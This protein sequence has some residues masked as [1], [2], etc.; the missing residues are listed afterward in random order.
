MGM[1]VNFP[2]CV[3]QMQA[4]GRP[5]PG[6]NPVQ[7][8]K[9]RILS[10]DEASGSAKNF[11]KPASDE[12]LDQTPSENRPKPR[13]LQTE[14][15]EEEDVKLFRMYKEYGSRWAVIVKNFKGKTKDGLR[16]RFYSTLR[17]IYRK[18]LKENPSS[19]CKKNLLDYV[20]D[21]I[22]Y[23]HNCFCKR[24]RPKKNTKENDKMQEVLEEKKEEEPIKQSE[25]K[26][27]QPVSTTNPPAEFSSLSGSASNQVNNLSSPATPRMA[28]TNL[29]IV[30]LIKS[31]Q[32]FIYE[33]LLREIEG[34]RQWS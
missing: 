18:K 26:P 29:A 32:E 34:S 24:G 11:E 17:R 28:S 16:N 10:G 30:N 9:T 12:R 5:L 27:K 2:Y 31:Q 21:A 3:N 19:A 23:G 6:F 1:N 7:F 20:D 14:W 8:H 4:S 33:M 25:S 15:T 13:G 22:D